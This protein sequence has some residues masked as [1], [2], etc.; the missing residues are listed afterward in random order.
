VAQM[1]HAPA[2]GHLKGMTDLPDFVRL[3]DWRVVAYLDGEDPSGYPE[4]GLHG[5]PAGSA[6]GPDGD[7]YRAARVRYITTD[8]AGYGQSSRHRGR[9]VADQAKDVLAVADGLGI[10]RFSVMGGSRGGPHALACLGVRRPITG[11]RESGRPAAAAS[12]GCLVPVGRS[13]CGT[14]LYGGP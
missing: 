2:G 9:T 8:R 4:F 6:A 12:A 7:L 13:G 11:L 14:P 3:A 10:E 5:T 1:R